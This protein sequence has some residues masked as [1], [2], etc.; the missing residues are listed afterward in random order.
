GLTVSDIGTYKVEYTDANGCKVTSSNLDITGQPSDNL[1]VYPVPNQG[2]FNV[3]FYN[4]SNEQVTVRVF[5][6]KGAEVYS[7]KVLTTIPYTTINVDMSTN[8]PLA[9]GTYIVDI[10]GADGRL[11]GSKKIIVNKR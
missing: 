7:R 4:Q 2:V 10:R 3:R 9:N 5:D 11:M 6:A 1:Y 8:K